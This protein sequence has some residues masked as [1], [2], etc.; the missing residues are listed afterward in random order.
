VARSVF[1]FVRVAQWPQLV[2]AL[3]EEEIRLARVMS[4][5]EIR[6]FALGFFTPSYGGLPTVEA[7]GRA[8]VVGQGLP[9]KDD[10]EPEEV[11]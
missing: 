10:Q 7:L 11:A 3:I 2:E 9:I 5:G 8:R 1:E 4:E 6:R